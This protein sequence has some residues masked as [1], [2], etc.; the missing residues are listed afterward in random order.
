[1][2]MLSVLGKKKQNK[3][4]RLQ[5]TMRIIMKQL[6]C[7]VN[8]EEKFTSSLGKDSTHNRGNGTLLL[9]QS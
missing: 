1:M 3:D 6:K 8:N 7:T 5:E 9:L 4:L 2:K